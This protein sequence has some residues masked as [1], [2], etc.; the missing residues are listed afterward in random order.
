MHNDSR[1]RR[2]RLRCGDETIVFC[3]RLGFVRFHGYSTHHPTPNELKRG[4]FGRCSNLSLLAAHHKDCAASDGSL[5]IGQGLASRGF[6]KFGKVPDVLSLELHT[7]RQRWKYGEA[8]A[9]YA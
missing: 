3:T 9:A 1:R 2:D 7:I 5:D 4:G 8:Q 6:A